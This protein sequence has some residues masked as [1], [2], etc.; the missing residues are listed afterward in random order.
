MELATLFDDN[1]FQLKVFNLADIF[2]ILNELSYSLQGKNK[3][4]IEVVRKGMVQWPPP[5]LGTPVAVLD[6]IS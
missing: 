2:C 3:S 4:Q 5:P 1:R 6:I